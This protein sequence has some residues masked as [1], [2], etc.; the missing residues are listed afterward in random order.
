MSQKIKK[1]YRY[2]NN[3]NDKRVANNDTT[4]LEIMIQLYD[5]NNLQYIVSSIL[6]QL[7]NKTKGH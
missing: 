1:K 5:K 7:K 6:K 4:G 2:F 3:Q